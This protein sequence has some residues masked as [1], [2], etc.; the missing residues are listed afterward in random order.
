[1]VAKIDPKDLALTVKF[2]GGLH[3]RASE[4]EIDPR[5][6]ADG[7]NFVLDLENSELRNR[8]SFD[9]I[10]Q[11]PN[12]AEIRGGGS[13][14]MA[15]GTVSTL[16]QAGANVYEWDGLTTFT[17]VGTV[18]STAKL[19]GYWRSHN[20]TLDD[21]LLLTDL[22]LVDVVKEWDG[23]TFASVSFIDGGVGG[24]GAAFG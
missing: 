12:Q 24:S 1:M 17:K 21:K 8:A 7:A 18:V 10:G 11:V 4:D 9:L 20:W 5:E 15:D 19:R 2:G 16:I 6:A 14:L 3:T 23:T 22:S 13:L